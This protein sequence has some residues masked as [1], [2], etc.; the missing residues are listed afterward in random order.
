MKEFFILLESGMLVLISD[1]KL[2]LPVRGNQWIITFD[3][4]KY[5]LSTVYKT[6]TLIYNDSYHYES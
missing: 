1:F 5:N 2:V 6:G 4:E 3:Q